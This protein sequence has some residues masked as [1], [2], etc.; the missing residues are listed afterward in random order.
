MDNLHW[1]AAS[2]GEVPPAALK[3]RFKIRNG[4][5]QIN[6]KIDILIQRMAFLTLDKNSDRLRVQ[7]RSSICGSWKG[8]QYQI[9]MPL[10]ETK[11]CIK[12]EFEID[13]NKI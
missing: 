6:T 5:F 7:W 12:I 8:Q 1:V 3:V 9:D 13:F 11:F 4:I 2:N 10:G